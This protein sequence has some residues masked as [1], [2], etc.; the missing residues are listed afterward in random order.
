MK[1]LKGDE[2][3]AGVV[4]G[5]GHEKMGSKTEKISQEVTAEDGQAGAGA[6]ETCLLSD[7]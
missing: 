3:K 4:E 1:M 2:A 6:Q 5:R 7:G